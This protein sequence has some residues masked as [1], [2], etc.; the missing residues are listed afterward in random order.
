MERMRIK[1]LSLVLAV[2]F[3]FGLL[4]GCG[5]SGNEPGS[6]TGG[7]AD[8]TQS[9]EDLSPIT[10]T[11]L[12]YNGEKDWG[13]DEISKE[14]TRLTGITLQYIPVGNDADEKC[15]ILLAS[16]DI[17]DLILQSL[18]GNIE[19]K[20]VAAGAVLQLDDLVDQYGPNIKSAYG[21]GLDLLRSR[22]DG[23][24][25][26]LSCWYNPTSAGSPNGAFMMRKDILKEF[27]PEK[28]E[29]NGYF[30]FEEY[31]SLLKKVKAKYPDMIPYLPCGE[32]LQ[33]WVLWPLRGFMGIYNYS[34]QGDDVKFYYRDPK[35]VEAY[36]LL[37]TIYREGLTDPEWAVM[38]RDPFMEKC[39]SGKVFSS[40]G[41]YWDLTDANSVL[42]KDGEDKQFFPYKVVGPGADPDNLPVG[43]TPALGWDCVMI[44]KNCKDPARLMKLLDFFASKE[45][46]RLCYFGIEGTHYDLIDGKPVPKENIIASVKDGSW[47][48]VQKAVG[49]GNWSWAIIDT[50]WDGVL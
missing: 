13:K 4:S 27:E 43:G 3:L 17:P 15:N 21:K 1:V 32:N 45:G 18:W 50:R 29:G 25:Y 40:S 8:S 11:A 41:A 33:W 37:N 23:K 9:S 10:F 42:A 28:A 7:K 31:I 49:F 34:V 44:G 24:L 12:C 16:G 48:D 26:T 5:A 19:N 35:F 36:K 14:I 30:T 20:Y 6:T 2:V 38:K 22:Y 46:H 39:A 47:D